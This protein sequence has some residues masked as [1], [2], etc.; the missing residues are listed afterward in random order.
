MQRPLTV[1]DVRFSVCWAVPTLV[2]RWVVG[3]LYADAS[4]CPQGV[5]VHRPGAKNAQCLLFSLLNWNMFR[6]N[7]WQML[8]LFQFKSC[9]GGGRGLLDSGIALGRDLCSGL[10]VW[11]M[12]EEAHSGFH[13]KKRAEAAWQEKRSGG[14]VMVMETDQ[15]SAW[16]SFAPDFYC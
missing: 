16:C 3:A 9:G 8:Y 7:S 14:G 6:S 4:V 15:L 12:G 11:R 1:G 10:G 2:R 13:E 5:T